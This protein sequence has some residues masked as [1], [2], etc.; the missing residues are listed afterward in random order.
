MHILA[1]NYFHL[2]LLFSGTFAK[3]PVPEGYRIV[4]VTDL[5]DEK[6]NESKDNPHAPLLKATLSCYKENHATL[7]WRNYDLWGTGCYGVSKKSIEFAAA[8]NANACMT[9]W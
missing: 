5:D 7:L 6:T 9:R 1:I 3:I 4:S 8:A 2:A